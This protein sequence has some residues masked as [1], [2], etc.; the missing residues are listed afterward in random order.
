[1]CE[2]AGRFVST[3]CDVTSTS[4]N[5]H[6]VFVYFKKLTCDSLIYWFK[7]GTLEHR[8]KAYCVMWIY[9]GKRY[10]VVYSNAVIL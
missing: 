2:Y 8:I 1:M 7:H 3:F 9:V 10:T 5:K 6:V 4:P